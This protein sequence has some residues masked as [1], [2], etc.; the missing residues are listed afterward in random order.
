[1][2]NYHE[3]NVASKN[4]EQVDVNTTDH[5]QEHKRYF[6][7]AVEYGLE[8]EMEI[9]D[10]ECNVQSVEQEYMAYTTAAL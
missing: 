10:L 3:K 7:I 1:M 5:T 2:H 8:N 9:G 6:D 4:E